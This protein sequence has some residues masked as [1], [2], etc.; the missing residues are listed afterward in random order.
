MK[1]IGTVLFSL[2][3][4]A[5]I[6]IAYATLVP[7]FAQQGQACLVGRSE[8]TLAIWSHRTGQQPLLGFDVEI[9]NEA[10]PAW[11]FA[12]SDDG[13]VAVLYRAHNGMTCVIVVGKDVRTSPALP[14]LELP[15]E[16][17]PG[18]PEL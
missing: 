2:L 6:I 14:A 4:W 13:S 10:M 12:N 18:G 5:L 9:D 7:A 17:N 3:L 1:L 8:E 16:V 11:L 15:E